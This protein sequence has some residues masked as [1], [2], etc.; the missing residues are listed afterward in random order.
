MFCYEMALFITY[1]S[2]MAWNFA[3]WNDESKV[4]EAQNDNMSPG[5]DIYWVLSFTPR[6]DEG[7]YRFCQTFR[8]QGVPT[9]H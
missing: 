5:L 7:I 1:V 4:R 6:A 3:L 8:Y 9:W 2:W